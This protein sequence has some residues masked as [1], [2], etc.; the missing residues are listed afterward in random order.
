MLPTLLLSPII[1]ADWPVLLAV[2]IGLLLPFVGLG[3]LVRGIWLLSKGE[4]SALWLMMGVVCLLLPWFLA[5]HFN[6]L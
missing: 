1:P 4:R 3:L 5:K 6:E 2:A